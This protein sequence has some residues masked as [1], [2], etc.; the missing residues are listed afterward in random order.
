MQTPTPN[1]QTITSAS[2]TF[3]SKATRRDRIHFSIIRVVHETLYGIFVDPYSRLTQA[4]LKNGCRV[5]EV[6]CGPGFFTIP[7][8]KIAGETGYVYALDINPA[9]VEH[10][11]RKVERDGLTNVRVDLADAAETGLAKESIDTVF[12]F[13]VMHS[14]KHAGRVMGEMHRVLRPAGILS[15]Q[16]GV[17]EKEIVETVC[18]N[19]M[20]SLRAKHGRTFIFAKM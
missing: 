17:P 18:A 19:G 14:L 4:G 3:D 9:A 15:V 12:L 16:S 7:A 8:A 13:G 2:S 6:G 1:A 20:F 11:K 10:V 5:L